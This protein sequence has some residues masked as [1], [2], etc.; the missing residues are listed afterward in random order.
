MLPKSYCVELLEEK[1]YTVICSNKN[2]LFDKGTIN[3]KDFISMPNIK[4]TTE[5]GV[6]TFDKRLKKLGLL[7]D[8]ILTLPDIESATEFIK[9]TDYIMMY[10]RI[11]IKP[12]ITG[13]NITMLEP[14]F[15]M[16]HNKLHQV[17]HAS[18]NED[19][20]HQWLHQYVRDNL[21]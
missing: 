11:L 19:P 3:K 18:K 5:I 8:E 6:S 15:E 20:A 2:K 12:F 7:Q 4:V 1:P 10:D 21:K 16:P 17:W 14:E 9:K 13:N